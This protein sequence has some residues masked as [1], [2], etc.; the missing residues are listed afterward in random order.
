MALKWPGT[1]PISL[2]TNEFENM[3]KLKLL[4][5]VGVNLYGDFKY[6]SKNLRWLYWHGFSLECIPPEFHQASL[7]AI[8]LEFSSVELV[9]K[10]TQV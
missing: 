9:W 4:Q 5:F 2:C 1:E 8:E 6:L 10:T 3:K 7:V